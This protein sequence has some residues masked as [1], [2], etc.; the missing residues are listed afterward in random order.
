[1]ISVFICE[2]SVLTNTDITQR[3]I[4][5]VFFSVLSSSDCIDFLTLYNG[6]NSAAKRIVEIVGAIGI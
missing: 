5:A 3:T 1:M 6:C 4:K 2:I